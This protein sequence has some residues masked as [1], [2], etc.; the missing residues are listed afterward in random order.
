[1]YWISAVCD[2]HTHQ[3]CQYLAIND[4]CYMVKQFLPCSL[5]IVLTWFIFN[6]MRWAS[7]Y[8]H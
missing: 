3:L 1:M 7:S 2:S 8:G 4:E 6:L 5:V